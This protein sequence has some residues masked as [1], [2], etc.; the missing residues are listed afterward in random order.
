[1][2][3]NTLKKLALAL[4]FWLAVHMSSLKAQLLGPYGTN[5]TTFEV[6]SNGLLSATGTFGTGSLSLSG[7]GTKMFWYPGK[8]AF[9]AGGVADVYLGSGSTDW[10]D[11]SIGQYSVAFGYNTIASGKGSTASGYYTTA[12]GRGSAAT[13]DGTTASGRYATAFGQFT[14][15]GGWGSAAFGEGSSAS[16]N[17]ST[18][19]G[20]YTSATALDSFVIGT[21]NLDLNADGVS[22]PST[23]SWVPTDP[24][25][26]IGNGGNSYGW[27]NPNTSQSSDALVVYKNGNTAVQGT[28]TAPTFITTTPAGDIP[29]Y[30]GN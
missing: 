20:N 5:P 8:G 2:H 15:A 19:S 21:G 29:M 11:A 1:M 23:D 22:A 10:D 17:Y 4:T 6:D 14:S 30:S 27:G 12:S 13:G 16:G 7:A 24:L 26:E 18:A 3:T 25:F 9:R 28:V